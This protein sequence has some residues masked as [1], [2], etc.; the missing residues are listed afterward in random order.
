MPKTL[1]AFRL[2]ALTL[3]RLADLSEW[4]AED[5]QTAILNECIAQA[6]HRE[7]YRRLTNDDCPWIVQPGN[8]I[9]RSQDDAIR[10]MEREQ[11]AVQIHT[12]PNDWAT[13]DE[14]DE[15]ETYWTL[16]PIRFEGE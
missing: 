4:W 11:G 5:N 13:F 6:W 14:D 1:K 10:W 9:F 2:S 8:H 12:G 3:A 16:A 15:A 7:A